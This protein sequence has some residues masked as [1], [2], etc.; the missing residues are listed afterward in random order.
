M[1]R[2]FLLGF[3]ALSGLASAQ[4]GDEEMKAGLWKEA[5][6]F[7]AFAIKNG[8]PEPVPIGETHDEE[9]CYSEEEMR[10]HTMLLAGSDDQCKYS[11]LKMADG[12]FTMRGHCDLGRGRITDGTYEG[13]YDATSLHMTG[14][15]RPVGSEPLFEL[16]TSFNATHVG[17]TCKPD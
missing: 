17:A 6:I 2:R 5:T 12:K 10:Q 9:D 7:T 14:V 15:Q 8:K 16:R 1:R 13:T 11:D 3:A 4:T